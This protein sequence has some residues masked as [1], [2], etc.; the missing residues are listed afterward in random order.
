[1]YYNN[2]ENFVTQESFNDSLLVVSNK[3]K[4]YCNTL[5]INNV[6]DNEFCDNLEVVLN[7]IITEGVEDK[8]AIFSSIKQ[9]LIKSL[10]KSPKEISNVEA[11][12]RSAIR[13][14]LSIKEKPWGINKPYV[15]IPS[16]E[17]ISWM[18]EKIKIFNSNSDTK[19]FDQEFLDKL[20][21]FVRRLLTT[22]YA[23]YFYYSVEEQK[24]VTERIRNNFFRYLI[25]NN[26]KIE[27]LQ[28]YL[29]M[30][31]KGNSFAYLQDQ[32]KQPKFLSYDEYVD[33]VMGGEQPKSFSDFINDGET[34]DP[35]KK[36]NLFNIKKEING[37]FK[38]FVEEKFGSEGSTVFWVIVYSKIMNTN[39]FYNKYVNKINDKNFFLMNICSCMLEKIFEENILN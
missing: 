21:E 33:K 15:N 5:D 34:N 37:G 6:M 20:D 36:Y 16:R 4:N 38:K 7:G 19:V 29:R 9:N 2:Q 8:E 24:I 28:A 18:H 11:Y 31:V 10:H 12:F 35:E 3:I 23:R 27:N 26:R 14:E 22:N 17:L 25:K 30:V 39:Y 13:K 32:Y 1:M